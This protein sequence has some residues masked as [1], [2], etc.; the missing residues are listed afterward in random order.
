LKHYIGLCEYLSSK[1]IGNE[2]I[3]IMETNLNI[4]ST[5]NMRE[6]DDS[7]MNFATLTGIF[8]AVSDT[9]MNDSYSSGYRQY[10]ISTAILQI[11]INYSLDWIV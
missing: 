9:I 5:A 8:T 1:D 4:N 3:S 6:R 11:L 7:T 2:I 10:K